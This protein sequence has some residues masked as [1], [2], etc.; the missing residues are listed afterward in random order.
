MNVIRNWIVT[1][2]R[3]R[4]ERNEEQLLRKHTGLAL[5]DDNFVGR[6]KNTMSR[7]RTGT[8]AEIRPRRRTSKR[9][10]LTEIWNER[11]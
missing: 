2:E 5:V 3:G 7:S 6:A 1:V 8:L 9:Q 4:R 10:G 11:M